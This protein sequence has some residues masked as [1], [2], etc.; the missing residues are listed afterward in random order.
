M[1]PLGQARILEH[2]PEG[3]ARGMKRA[4]HGSNDGT[5]S[6]ASGNNSVSAGSQ[7]ANSVDSPAMFSPQALQHQQAAAHQQMNAQPTA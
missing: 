2:I 1:V 6:I 7:Y 5:M 3:P 4:C